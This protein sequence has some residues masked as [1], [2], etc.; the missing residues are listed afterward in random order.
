MANTA[1]FH[2]PAQ[3]ESID[4]T[5]PRRSAVK[6]AGLCVAGWLVGYLISCV[7]SILFFTVGHIPPHQPASSTVMW[8]TAIYGI[9]FAVIGAIVGA[10]FARK[11]AL[12]I[13]AAIALTIGTAAL[14]SW[15][16]T[17]NAAHWTQVIAIFLMAPA[18]QF[19]A[20]FRRLDY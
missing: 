14:L 3:N 8:I 18:A 13:G 2:D 1:D 6:I 12:G 4:G 15:Y 10:N 7:S 16:E 9:V 17:P 20:L 19:G 5:A 11:Y